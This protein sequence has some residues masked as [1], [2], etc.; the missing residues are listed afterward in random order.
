MP[1]PFILSAA[2]FLPLVPIDAN[3][4]IRS[5]VKYSASRYL[6]ETDCILNVRSIFG[7]YIYAVWFIRDTT[8]YS[9]Y[10]LLTKSA[11]VCNI[12]EPKSAQKPCP[13]WL[14]LV[15]VSL[16]KHTA[17]SGHCISE[18]EQNMTFSLSCL[19]RVKSLAFIQVL[20]KSWRPSFVE[21]LS[22]SISGTD[23]GRDGLRTDRGGTVGH[24]RRRKEIYNLAV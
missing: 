10:L 1:P 13:Y 15:K 5:V 7:W 14:S 4:I 19:S 6:S 23:E 11:L 20:A 24:P 2:L 3:Y 16:I 21:S 18:R 8:K 22:V 12:F 17:C 9:L